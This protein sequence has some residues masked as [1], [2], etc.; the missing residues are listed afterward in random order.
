MKFV[1][2]LIILCSAVFYVLYMGDLSFYLLAFLLAMPVVL[3]AALAIGSAFLKI[4]VYCD[5]PVTERGKAAAIKINLYNRSFLPVSSCMVKIRYTVSAPFEE[6]L[7]YVH[8]AYVPIGGRT[9]ETVSLNFLPKHCGAISVTVRSVRLRDLMG[10]TS[11]R[12]KVGF[13]TRITVLPAILPISQSIE[14]NY[15]YSAESSVFSREKPGDDPSEIFMLREYRDGDRHN[16]IHWKL[17]GRSDNFIVRELSK[18]VGSRILIMA[19]T[20]SCRSAE[21]ADRVLEAAASVSCSLAESGAAHT[22]AVPCCGYS[23]RTS[24]ITDTDSLCAEL[25]EI[26]RGVKEL[27]YGSSIAYV[28]EITDSVFIANGGFSRVIAVSEQDGGAYADELSSICGEARLTVICTAS[29][30]DNDTGSSMEVSAVEF[31]YADAE[32]L[33]SENFG[34]FENADIPREG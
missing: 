18:P 16:L 13:S 10:I 32:K 2:F 22:F 8:T 20:G 14:S 33:S 5:S 9:S 23:L 29:Q 27:E 4:K 34:Y 21:G 6:E 15:I 17:S 12:K 25:A 11:V 7:P 31:I 3:Y 1:Y 19:D 30:T 26:C 24:E 28:T